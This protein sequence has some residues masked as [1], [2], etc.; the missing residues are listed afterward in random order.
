MKILI[1]CSN[2]VSG[3]GL[4]VGLGIVNSLLK[5]NFDH[6]FVV[7]IP[8]NQDFYPSDNQEHI[9][10]IHLSFSDEHFFGKLL[11]EK[12]IAKIAK[13]ERCE[14]ILS[15]SNYA[16]PSS[17]PQILMLHWPY[18]VYPETEI[19]SKM[20]VI[21]F[22]KRKIRLF[23]FK[24]L[25]PFAER[26]I[27]QTEVMK[28]RALKH[29]KYQKN[30]DVIPSS[31]GFLGEIDNPVILHKIKDLKSSGYKVFLCINEYYEHKNLEIL[32]PLAQKVLDLNLKIRFLITLNPNQF[33]HK[34]QGLE[35]V[36]VNLGRISR[37]ETY[38]VFKHCD[39]LFFPSLIES[40]GIPL[41]EAK[42]TG[43]PV[44]ASDRDF[45]KAVCGKE[46]VYF[47]PNDLDDILN[48]IQLD[49]IKSINQNVMDWDEITKKMITKLNE[50]ER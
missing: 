39:A 30:I 8:S 20:S 6:Q 3:G 25:L 29:L 46:A 19:W 14:A 48:K 33:T 16:I 41:V 40:F 28:K 15:L 4:T 42:K 45:A 47:N 23:K 32:I 34:L 11:L 18:A 43:L 50:L 38:S 49:P 2:L 1:N 31:V 24:S 35:Q 9:T 37:H 5:L 13:N 7:V 12:K 21:N 36:I 44:Y 10:F 22:V 27:V 17:L 26:M